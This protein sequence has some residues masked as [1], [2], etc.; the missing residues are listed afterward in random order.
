MGFTPEQIKGRMLLMFTWQQANPKD[1]LMVFWKR[2]LAG[3]LYF[4]RTFR[5]TWRFWKQTLSVAI[6]INLEMWSSFQP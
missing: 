1:C 2:W 3:Y 4:Y 5:S 6:P